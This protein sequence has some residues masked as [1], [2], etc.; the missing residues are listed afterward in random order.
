MKTSNTF[1][2]G[3]VTDYHPLTVPNTVLV[4]ALNATIITTEGNEKIL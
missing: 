1:I 2:G 3:L 4:D